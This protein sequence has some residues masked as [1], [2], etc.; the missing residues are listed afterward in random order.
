MRYRNSL[1]GIKDVSEITSHSSLAENFFNN[2]GAK[3][4]QILVERDYC[5]KKENIYPYSYI[6]DLWLDM[7]LTY[8]GPLPIH[9]SVAVTIKNLKNR[10]G[11]CQVAAAYI[12][13]ILRFITKMSS[14]VDVV[15]SKSDLLRDLSPLRDQFSFARLPAMNKDTK[16]SLDSKD[17]EYVTIL[18]RGHMHLLRIR[19]ST[20]Y[21]TEN[22]ICEA[23]TAIKNANDKAT[24]SVPILTSQ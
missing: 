9:N 16:L 17:S 13:G 19:D 15:N 4:Q 11:Q 6:E 14:G 20:G 22:L 3:L 2:S 5:N 10:K 7:Y 12:Y 21:Y 18:H 23:L 8:R 24:C 1:L